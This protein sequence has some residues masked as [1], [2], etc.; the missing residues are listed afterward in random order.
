M[1]FAGRLGVVCREAWSASPLR[2]GVQVT[3]DPLD[4][5]NITPL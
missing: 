3:S 2:E 5:P 4:L 1:A